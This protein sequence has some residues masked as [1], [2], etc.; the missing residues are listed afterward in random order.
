MVINSVE[1]AKELI[2]KTKTETGLKVKVNIIKKI[3]EKGKKASKD[4]VD[5]IKIKRDKNLGY[6]N[7]EILPQGL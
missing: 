2:S 3:Y 4:L 7:Y 1:E 5:N 6:L